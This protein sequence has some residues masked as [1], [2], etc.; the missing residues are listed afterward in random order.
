MSIH[1]NNFFAPNNTSLANLDEWEE[2]V[3]N[4]YPDPSDINKDKKQESL[5]ITK[6]PQKLGLK[7]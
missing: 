2:D 4:R 3:L 7:K 5:G 1:K 6:K